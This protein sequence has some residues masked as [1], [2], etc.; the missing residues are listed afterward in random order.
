MAS[1]ARI[2]SEG[3]RIR[4]RDGSRL[5]SKITDFQSR[6]RHTEHGC[7]K[8]FEI[9]SRSMRR[10][11]SASHISDSSQLVIHQQSTQS[12]HSS[13]STG[14]GILGGGVL[15]ASPHTGLL[16][17]QESPSPLQSQGRMTPPSLRRVGSHQ[18]LKHGSGLGLNVG[19]GDVSMAG[20]ARGSGYSDALGR[21]VLVSGLTPPTMIMLAGQRSHLG[22]PQPPNGLRL[23]ASPMPS[24][25]DSYGGQSGGVTTPGSC[26]GGE[27]V[28]GQTATA[29]TYYW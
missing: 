24:R 13:Q 9:S 8:R 19:G 20:N 28:N 23:Q 18:G 21:S 10:A 6:R 25:N 17:F 27:D 16:G 12:R 4:F 29:S 1:L 2:P 5:W 22:S 15:A 11:S 7:A 14:P 3:E 26:A